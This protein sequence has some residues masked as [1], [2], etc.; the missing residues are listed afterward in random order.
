MPDLGVNIDHVATIREARGVDYPDPVKAAFIAESSGADSIVCHLREDRRHIQDAD[1][2][3]LKKLVKVK[4]NLEMAMSD[5][6]VRI[7]LDV[8]PDQITLV[9]EKRK[10]LTT[11]GGLNVLSEKKKIKK[12]IERMTRRGIAVSLF[13]DP[14]LRQIK[15][16]YDAGARMIELH[17]GLYANAKNKRELKNEYAA[18]KKAA[19]F[20]KKL[21]FK[22][23]AG[24]GLHYANTRPLTRI[25]DIEE[26]N[27]GH[28]IIARAVFVGF[29]RAVREMKGIVK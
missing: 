1:L 9:P 21:G 13:V 23:F 29:G 16:A 5:E 4:L 27:I 2:R 10:E 26:Y 28:S 25:K 3:R 19:E 14:L 15:A 7:A 24:H 8:R 17:T 6:I 22:V 20:A 11:E 18:L 12:V